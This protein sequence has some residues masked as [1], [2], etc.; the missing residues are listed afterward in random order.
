MVSDRNPGIFSVKGRHV[1]YRPFTTI[2]VPVRRSVLTT[3]L[4]HSIRYIS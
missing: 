3:L 4:S 1:E 2:I